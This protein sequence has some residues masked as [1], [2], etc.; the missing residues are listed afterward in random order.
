MFVNINKQGS[1]VKNSTRKH[2]KREEK[3]K[4]NNEA[5]QDARQKNSTPARI[6]AHAQW[7]L[8]HSRLNNFAPENFLGGAKFVTMNTPQKF[9][10]CRFRLHYES[11]L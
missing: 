1:T 9:Q 8:R 10:E 2:T 11:V 3:V 5:H 6:K 4:L 7:K